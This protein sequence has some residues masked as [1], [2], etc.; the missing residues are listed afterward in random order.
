[1][2][3]NKTTTKTKTTTTTRRQ[4]NQITKAKLEKLK[5]QNPIKDWAES[6]FWDD[7]VNDNS[8]EAGKQLP[9]RKVN[10]KKKNDS[11]KQ[12]WKL[13]TRDAGEEIDDGRKKKNLETT[14]NIFRLACTL[15]HEQKGENP[16]SVQS[17]YKKAKRND[18]KITHTNIKI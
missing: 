9:N 3:Q 13:P 6:K 14:S 1:M 7:A 4:T 5:K 16:S 12:N 11:K 17:A 2:R 8:V 15:V 18:R 10:L